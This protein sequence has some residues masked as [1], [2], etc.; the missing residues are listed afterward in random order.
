M[1][2][3]YIFIYISAHSSNPDRVTATR[4]TLC[5]CV[6]VCIYIYFLTWYF[7]ITFVNSVVQAISVL[8][9]FYFIATRVKSDLLHLH[10]TYPGIQT[11]L[12]EFEPK[13]K[14]LYF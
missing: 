13:T 2:V 6:C 5:V 12:T 4:L 9:N 7:S 14:S 8:Q 1:C 3:I 10:L 11:V